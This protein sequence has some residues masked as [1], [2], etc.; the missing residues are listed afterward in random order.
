MTRAKI[1]RILPRTN[2][3]DIIEG[4]GPAGGVGGRTRVKNLIIKKIDPSGRGDLI[5]NKQTAIPGKK[6]KARPNADFEQKLNEIHRYGTSIKNPDIPTSVTGKSNWK[7]TDKIPT[8]FDIS[9]TKRG[10]PQ[11]AAVIK[12]ANEAGVNKQGRVLIEGKYVNAPDVAQHKQI[13]KERLNYKSKRMEENKAKPGY[14]EKQAEK[15]TKEEAIRLNAPKPT[16]SEKKVQKVLERKF[17]IR[18]KLQLQQDQ[19]LRTGVKIKSQK[20]DTDTGMVKSEAKI[21][22]RGRL[23]TEGRNYYKSKKKKKST[24]DPIPFQ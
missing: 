22:S 11:R 12:A 7:A 18:T 14:Q 8:P 5:V 13:H 17:D 19:G 9:K 6:L 2:S 23:T 1:K 24:G 16:P 3:G 15:R 4:F 10:S 21:Q 20:I